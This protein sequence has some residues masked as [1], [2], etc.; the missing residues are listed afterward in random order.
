MSQ[1]VLSRNSDPIS[2]KLAAQELVS[3]GKFDNQ[4]DMVCDLLRNFNEN[5]IC[6]TSAEMAAYLDLDRYIPSRRLPDL[7]KEGRVTRLKT[8]MCSVTKKFCVTWKVQGFQM[9]KEQEVGD[10]LAGLAKV[11]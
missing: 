6:P 11:A 10:D 9:A 1:A 8:R 3:S 5:N 7:E 2:S 4:K